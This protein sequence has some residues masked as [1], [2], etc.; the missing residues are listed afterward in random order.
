MLGTGD[1]RSSPIRRET[2]GSFIADDVNSIVL[3]VLKSIRTSVAPI[4][5]RSEWVEVSVSRLE[6]RVGAL[7]T[8]I[9]NLETV[10]RKQRRDNAGMLVMMK[11]TAG[12]F[13]ER[14]TL[15]EERMEALEIEGE[16]EVDVGRDPTFVTARG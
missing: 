12:D 7:E 16:G 3:D 11:A 15:M 10:V 6:T 9:G 1:E 14:V 5:K 8:R 13:D 4:D 2:R